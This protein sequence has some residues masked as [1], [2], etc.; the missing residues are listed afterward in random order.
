MVQA[1][2][3]KVSMSRG[4]ISKSFHLYKLDNLADARSPPEGWECDGP[5]YFW[6]EGE[7]CCQDVSQGEV[8][9]EEVHP[10]KLR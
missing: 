3:D 2:G 1:S 4:S 6:Q 7:D 5:G 9:Q 8:H 10:A